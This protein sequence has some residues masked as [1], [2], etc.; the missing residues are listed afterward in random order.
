MKI[1]ITDD[2]IIASFVALRA[3]LRAADFLLDR[4]IDEGFAPL[5]Q[6]P[7]LNEIKVHVT[8][9]NEVIEALESFKPLEPQKPTK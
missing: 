3:R 1:Q 6:D 9:A 4:F 5:V 8:M 7:A 2:R